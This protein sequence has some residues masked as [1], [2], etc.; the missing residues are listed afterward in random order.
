MLSMTNDPTAFETNNSALI[1]HLKRAPLRALQA[2]QKAGLDGAKFAVADD[3]S[4]DED[5]VRDQHGVTIETS[6]PIRRYLAALVDG[7]RGRYGLPASI[8]L[9]DHREA[10]E[11][12]WPAPDRK[13]YPFEPD[14]IREGA[15]RFRLNKW[16]QERIDAAAALR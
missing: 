6:R 16:R 7:K 15:K 13:A 9:T 14:F 4:I 1:G 2:L 11:T 8:I 12:T 3:A 5:Q 10:L